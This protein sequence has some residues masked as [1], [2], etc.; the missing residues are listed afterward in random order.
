[1]CFL[2]RCDPDYLL[3]H[4]AKKVTAKVTKVDAANQLVHLETGSSLT[5]DKLLVGTGSLPFVPPVPGLDL[6]GVHFLASLSDSHGIREWIETGKNRCVVIGAGFV[7]IEAAV[8]L[9]KLGCQVTVVE[10]LTWVLPRV[11]DEDVAFIAQ[12]HLEAGGIEFRLGAQ[13]TE[14]A[15]CEEGSVDAVMLG[16]ERIECDTV[17]VGIGVRPNIGFL[18]GTDVETHHGILVGDDM[19]TSVPGIYAAGDVVEVRSRHTGSPTLGAIWPNAIAQ[20]K[21]AGIAMAGKEV[22]Y[23]GSEMLNVINLFEVPAVSLGLTSF[24]ADGEKRDY[25]TVV[26]SPPGDRVFKKLAAGLGG[27]IGSQMV[28]EVSNAG[29]IVSYLRNVWDASEIK[30]KVL[31]GPLPHVLIRGTP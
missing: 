27:P 7:G 2:D 26:F 25:E 23:D 31:R 29:I 16:E 15:P 13:V 18:D 20:G 6:E 30:E 17:V 19:Q 14:V 8:A 24:L 10:M 9:A 22:W 21:V 1:E 28:G 5:Y 3:I 11:F 12:K 4:D